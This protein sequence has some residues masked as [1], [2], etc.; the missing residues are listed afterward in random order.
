[1]TKLFYR[2]LTQKGFV[3]VPSVRLPPGFVSFMKDKASEEATVRVLLNCTGKASG[4]E[5]GEVGGDALPVNC[6]HDALLSSFTSNK[7]P[8]FAIYCLVPA[9]HTSTIFSG[10][11]L[12]E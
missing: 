8:S 3:I 12:S 7:K 2:L 6:I 5:T 1:M 10:S 9:L 4:S 11:H